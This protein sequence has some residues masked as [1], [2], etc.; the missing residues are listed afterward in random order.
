LPEDGTFLL[1][2]SATTDQVNDAFRVAWCGGQLRA[3]EFLLDQLAT[4]NLLP[5]W[6]RLT[7]LDAAVRSGATHVITWLDG[8]DARTASNLRGG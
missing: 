4:L 8:H 3:A 6:S 5:G 2:W 7:P 1:R